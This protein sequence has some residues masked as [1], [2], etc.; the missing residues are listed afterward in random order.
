MQRKYSTRLD[1]VAPSGERWVDKV[2]KRIPSHLLLYV[3]Y[4]VPKSCTFT[5]LVQEKC[6]VVSFNLGH[7]V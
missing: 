2:I 1:F 7:R 3:V 5:H 4:N 6:K